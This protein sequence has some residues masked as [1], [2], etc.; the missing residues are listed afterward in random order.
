MILGIDTATPQRWLNFAMP[1]AEGYD[2][3]YV[4]NGGDNVDPTYES[5]YYDEQIDKAR[6]MGY[7]K[8]GHYWVPN[9]DPADADD[10]DTPVQ[11]A[12]FMIANLRNWNPATDFIVLDNESLD[13]A[14]RFNDA[15]AAE[16]IGRVKARLSI[17]GNQVLTYLGLHDAR[18]NEW[19]LTL[20]TG[21][22][23]IVAAY[24]YAPFAWEDFPS[25]P[26]A[27]IAGH[28]FGEIMPLNNYVLRSPA[29]VILADNR[30]PY[31]S[32]QNHLAR[33]GR[34]GVDIVAPIG[35]PVYARTSGVMLHVPNDGSAG[36]SC[37]FQHDANPGW[38]DVFS[39][40]SRYVGAS[41][42]HF[43]AGDIVAY[44]GISGGVEPHLH[45]HLV[46]PSGARRNPWDYFSGSSTAGNGGT[47]IEE[48]KRKRPTMFLLHCSMWGDWLIVPGVSARKVGNED[49]TNIL[50][51]AGAV[52][53]VEISNENWNAVFS[54]AAGFAGIDLA[55][56]E[57]HTW[58]NPD[59][60]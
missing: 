18:S 23:F 27:R 33:A 56:P 29:T 43:N 16:F 50:V 4:K 10:I 17:P 36:N 14:I 6:Y 40:L 28:Q 46:D 3:T 20:A 1:I 58:V 21:T 8:I 41:G 59:L 22:N 38:R 52:Q 49:A 26:R 11:Q 24:S 7:K 42:Q 2:R 31:T 5:P 39:H 57:G 32:W 30:D 15:Q 45:W 47:P 48:P 60:R 55:G 12:D 35:T 53:R 19:P 9:A 51:A 13:G 44:T 54:E 37:R 25:I 34:G